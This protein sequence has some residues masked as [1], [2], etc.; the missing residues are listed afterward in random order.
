[1]GSIRYGEAE[2]EFEDRALAHVKA[3]VSTKLR[4]KESCFLNWT[5][6]PREGGG[7]VTLWISPDTPLIFRFS[8][9]VPPELNQTWVRV[10]LHFAGTPQGMRIVSE[11][12]AEDF[13]RRRGI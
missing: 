7:R 9:S 3:A 10:L 1:M 4:R 11:Q 2:Y 8:A 5:R 13:A 12:D 6:A